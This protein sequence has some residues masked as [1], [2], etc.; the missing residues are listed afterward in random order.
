MSKLF[1][2]REYLDVEDTA[3]YLAI[4]F[5]EPVTSKDVL[6]L[7]MEE[8]IP[9]SVRFRFPV[10]VRYAKLTDGIG[11]GE[12]GID[13]LYAGS[14]EDKHLTLFGERQSLEGVVDLALIGSYTRNLISSSAWDGVLDTGISAD[15]LLLC[16]ENGKLVALVDVVTLGLSDIPGVRKGEFSFSFPEGSQLVIRMSTIRSLEESLA[17][18]SYTSELKT[19]ERRTLLCIIA[20]L[21]KE[22]DIGYLP[23]NI[24][25]SAAYIESLATQLG[26][27]VSKRAIE[28]HLKLIPDALESRGK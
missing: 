18:H 13:Y 14:E 1:T 25:K 6:N 23:P 10:T 24:G 27:H 3:R 26:A 20:A 4:N 9:I 5:N 12:L 21:A 8:K 16:D 19:K 17:K 28:E 7:V 15:D 22:A 11:T 2:L